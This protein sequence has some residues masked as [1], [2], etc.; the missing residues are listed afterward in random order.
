[1]QSLVNDAVAE[2]LSKKIVEQVT[3]ALNEQWATMIEELA[4]TR[5]SNEQLRHIVDRLEAVYSDQT[6]ILGSKLEKATLEMQKTA[7]NNENASKILSETLKDYG[8]EE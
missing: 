6:T 4:S 3:Q 8:I 2:A 1:M 7:R 5:K